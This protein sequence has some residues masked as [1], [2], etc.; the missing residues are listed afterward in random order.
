MI[1]IVETSFVVRP[2]PYDT[3]AALLN[4]LIE[5]QLDVALDRYYTIA[6][7]NIC[8]QVHRQRIGNG[9]VNIVLTRSMNARNIL[10]VVPSLA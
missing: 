6:L 9:A 2:S 8:I 5:A 7:R 3:A 1:F 10:C 4:R